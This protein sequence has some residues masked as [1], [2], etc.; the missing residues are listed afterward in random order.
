MST[1]LKATLAHITD[2]D[3]G[4]LLLCQPIN[5]A[6]PWL[7]ADTAPVVGG[8]RKAQMTH[9]YIRRIRP[10][11]CSSS[12]RGSRIRRKVQTP[13]GLQRAQV[14]YQSKSK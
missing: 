9:I 2:G 1:L 8:F 14:L 13:L 11:R 6:L 4:V 12:R 3:R 5:L 7:D 10:S